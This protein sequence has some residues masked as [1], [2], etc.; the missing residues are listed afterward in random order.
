MNK[1][2]TSPFVSPSFELPISSKSTA[3]QGLVESN[4]AFSILISTDMLFFITSFKR[5]RASNSNNEKT[6][7]RLENFN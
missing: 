4:S 6:I 7:V 5:A 3:S 2:T 1:T